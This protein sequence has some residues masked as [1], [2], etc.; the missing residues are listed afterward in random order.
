MK[1]LPKYILSAA[2][3]VAS[4]AAA[5]AQG[6]T[7]TPSGYTLRWSDEF[8]GTQLNEAIWNIEVNGNGGGNQELQYYRRENVAVTTDPA[9]G[10]NCLVLTARRETYNGRSFTSGRVTTQN[11]AAFKHGILQAR[12]KFPK[13][14]NGLW[15]AYWM[16]GN[17]MNRYG[18]PRCG[19]MDIVELGHANGIAAGTQDRY[20]G[21]TLHFG[22]NATNEGHQYISQEYTAPEDNPLTND[23]YHIITVEWDDNNLYMYYDLQSYSAANKRKARYFTQSV[24]YEE[25]EYSVGH[26]F[27]KTYFFLFNLA[28][29]GTFPSI[30]DPAGITALPNAG[31]E[32]KMYIDWVRVYQKDDDANAQYTY[33]DENGDVVTNIEVEPEPDVDPDTKTPLS[34]FATKALDEDGVTTFDFN[35]VSDVVLISTSDGVTGHF[36]SAG[37]NV[38]DLNVNDDNRNLYIW[39]NTYVPMSYTNGV[40]SFGWEE[41]YTKYSVAT[42]GWSGLGFNILGEDLSMV[43]DTYWLHFA[44]RGVDQDVH[45]SHEVQFAKARFIVG[46]S[47]GA[48]ASVGDFPRDGEWYYFDIPLSALEQFYTPV[49]GST[50]AQF[51]DN[52]ISFLSGGLTDAE[53][54]YDNIFIYKSKTKEIPTFTD[55]NTDNLGKYGY[56]SLDENGAAVF[57]FDKVVDVVPLFLSQDTWESLTAGG[58]YGEGSLVKESA[59]NSEQGGRNNFFIWGDPQTMGVKQVLDTPNSFGRTPYGGFPSYTSMTDNITWNGAGWA[60]LAGQGMTPSPKDLSMIDDT[61]YLHF[62]VRS[63]AAVGH[64]PVM[65]RIGSTDKDATIVLGSYAKRPIVADFPRDGQWY[66]FDIPVAELKKYGELWSN[67]AEKGGITAYTD[68]TLCIYTDQTFYNNS[69]FSL[70]NV[71]FYKTDEA[72]EVNLLGEYTTKSLDESGNSYFDFSNKEFIAISVNGAVLGKMY[73]SGSEECVLGDYRDGVNGSHFYNWTGNSYTIGTQSQTVPDSFG[74]DEGWIDLVTNGGWTGA[75]FICDNGADFSELENGDWYLHFAMRGTDDCSHQITFAAAKFTIGPKIFGDG[76]PILGD[77]ARDGEW[78]SYDI[79]YSVLKSLTTDMFPANDGGI[80]AYTNNIMTIMSGGGYGDEIQIDN[81][82]LYREKIAGIDNIFND[83]IGE[84]VEKVVL[85]IYDVMGRTVTDMEQPG[86]YIVRTNLGTKK[87][88]VR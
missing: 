51:N 3:A 80:S 44:M 57:S 39:E 31:D 82:F 45:T 67:A 38:V 26:Y 59:D 43:D 22:P 85:G 66:S 21:G 7:D 65:I 60:S 46:N 1:N 25:G 37:A 54:C 19:E 24:A 5:E 48:L 56:K 49:L 42:V 53:L 88:L 68:Y 9:T 73:D 55:T 32:A 75:G 35:D 76:A 6:I 41:G 36:K 17:D 81:I 23:E 34:S 27:Q 29:G 79:P 16:M 20:F 87:V 15:P 4:V 86:I 77:Y 18:W 84:A 58:T 28:V 63:D 8:N 33:V 13:V 50:P 74:G 2:F 69:Y 83:E 52:I 40:N 11:N 71:F 30:Y 47:N 64:V 61:Y 78:Y 14:A 10:E 62:S 12:I 72:P 70:D